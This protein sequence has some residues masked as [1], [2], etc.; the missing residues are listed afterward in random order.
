VK[1]A[2]LS[3]GDKVEARYRG[4]GRWYPGKIVRDRGDGTYD[5]NYDDGEAETRVASDMIRAKDAMSSPVKGARLSEGDK[6][7]AR[8][9]VL[10]RTRRR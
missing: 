7:E 2:R 1:G 6:V 10:D 8:Y 5:V 3:E 9:R 4:R